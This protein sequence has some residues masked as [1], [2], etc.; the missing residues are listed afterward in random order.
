MGTTLS[1]GIYDMSR[2]QTDLYAQHDLY[3]IVRQSSAAEFEEWT[4]KIFLSLC[5]HNQS[6][7]KRFYYR[8][9]GFSLVPKRTFYV[10]HVSSA[11]QSLAIIFLI[12]VEHAANCQPL[13]FI[14][15]QSCFVGNLDVIF[16]EASQ[17]INSCKLPKMDPKMDPNE[18]PTADG[19]AE[20]QRQT[21]FQSQRVFQQPIP[22]QKHR[23]CLEV[24]DLRSPKEA[25]GEIGATSTS[26][27]TARDKIIQRLSERAVGS[28]IKELANLKTSLK[29]M[30]PTK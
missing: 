15:T 19:V 11:T 10:L 23:Q 22:I 27:I 6:T 17:T 26:G 30:Q 5:D 7:P 13:S 8:L 16:R 29:P 20:S 3:N 4:P 9:L 25:V 21:A 28:W 18:L 14:I 12:H 24:A 1:F 2:V